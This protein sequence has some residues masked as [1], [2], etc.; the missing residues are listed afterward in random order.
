QGWGGELYHV[1]GS[2]PDDV[3]AVG[4]RGLCMHFDG[5]TWHVAPSLGEADLAGVWT[6][7]PGDGWVVDESGVVQH[8]DGTEWFE[9]PQSRDRPG[10]VHLLAAAATMSGARWMVGLGGAIA[11]W[12]GK[13]LAKVLSGTQ[14]SLFSIWQRA[15]DDVWAVGDAGTLLH[16]DGK[17]WKSA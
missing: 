5:S 3:W 14:N 11:R 6:D 9:P 8:F 13:T 12:D 4:R 15:P 17:S 1:M 16:Y 7:G 2:R 10:C